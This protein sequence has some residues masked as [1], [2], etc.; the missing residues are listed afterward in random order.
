MATHRF[1]KIE[2]L[3]G[4]LIEQRAKHWA[5]LCQDLRT[6]GSSRPG[7]D[8][9]LRSVSKKIAQ[10]FHPALPPQNSFINILH[11]NTIDEDSPET[12]QAMKNGGGKSTKN[13]Q[14]H[15]VFLKG[16]ELN[17]GKAKI[18]RSWFYHSVIE[19][20]TKRLP[21][22]DLVLMLKALDKHFGQESRRT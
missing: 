19:S 8:T 20:L 3:I 2:G 5:E 7:S 17:E 11:T 15:L 13:S 21:E 1:P 6:P 10:S 9:G 16:I 18:N 22:S 4:F 14:S 12:T